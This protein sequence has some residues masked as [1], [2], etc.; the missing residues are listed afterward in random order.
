MKEKKEKVELRPLLLAWRT[1]GY[2]GLE[3]LGQVPEGTS[4]LDLEE[5]HGYYRYNVYV[6]S[7]PEFLDAYIKDKFGSR[8]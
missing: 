7:L 6:G 3:F 2:E 5:S 4:E 1:G 8:E